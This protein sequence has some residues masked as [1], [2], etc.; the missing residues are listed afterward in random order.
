VHQLDKIK[1]LII[2]RGTVQL[3]KKE[4][5]LSVKANGIG[6]E[7]KKMVLNIFQHMFGFTQHKIWKIL[8]IKHSTILLTGIPTLLSR[9]ES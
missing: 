6:D 2:S 9:W 5:I 8:K 7:T 1:D 3:G 4:R